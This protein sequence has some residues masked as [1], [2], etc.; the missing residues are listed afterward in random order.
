MKISVSHASIRL[1]GEKIIYFD[2]YDIYHESHDADYIFITHDHYD[3][4]SSEDIDK[5]KNDNTKIIVP[6]CLEHKECSLVVGVGEEYSIDGITFKTIPSYNIDKSYHPKSKEYVG[7]N[8]LL[9]DKYYYIM[10]DTDRTDEA[11]LVKTDICFV[12][13]GGTF[14]MDYKEAADYINYIKPKEVIPIHYGKI[15]GDVSLGKEFKNLVNDDIKVTLK[16]GGEE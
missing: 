11:D 12:P 5:V 15:V 6:K 8:I 2:P 14:T 13:I 9:E 10:G 3:H 4:Y 1:E 7:Y 16:I